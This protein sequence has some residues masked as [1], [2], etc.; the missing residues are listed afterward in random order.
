MQR[1][2]ILALVGAILIV[3]FAIQNAT[4]VEVLK[5]WFWE[6]QDS[7]LALIILIT[8]AIGALLGIAVSIPNYRKK[9]KT[10][11]QL[12]KKLKNC[13]EGENEQQQQPP[14]VSDMAQ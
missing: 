2:L 12:R 3:I 4:N 1:S 5:L 11:E 6:I 13:E 9:T 14:K 8:L 10:I 7:P